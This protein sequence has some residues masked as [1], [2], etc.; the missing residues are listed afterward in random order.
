MRMHPP[1]PVLHGRMATEDVSLGNLLIPK[2]AQVSLDI[3]ELH[4]NPIVWK[5]PE[6]F[7]PLRFAPRGEV[8]Q[9]HSQGKLPWIPFNHHPRQCIGKDF[10]LRAL[11]MT[12]AMLGMNTRTRNG[13]VRAVFWMLNHILYSSSA[14]LRHFTP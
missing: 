7:D 13:F 4:H 6:T 2:G 5:N 12:L 11:T 3:Y 10:S 14:M 8:D 1:T 9:L